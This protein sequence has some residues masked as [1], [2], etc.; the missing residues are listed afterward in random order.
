M[1]PFA[2]C[3]SV[4]G[5]CLL[6]SLV[7]LVN[8]ELIVLSAAAAAPRSLLL[9]IVLI[10]ATTQILAKS[11]LYLVGGGML[12]L[13]HNRYTTRVHD[14]LARAQQHRKVGSLALFASAATGFPPFYLTSIASGAVRIP[15]PQFVSIGFIGRLL[16]FSAIVLLPLAIKAVL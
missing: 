15:F 5:G 7:P 11:L 13:P 4:F 16:R 12:R 6:G 1:S 14:T 3:F 10:A 8:T 9:P 2:L